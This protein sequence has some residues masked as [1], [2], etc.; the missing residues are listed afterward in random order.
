V[1]ALRKKKRQHE[2]Q[3][4]NK[5]DGFLSFNPPW[6]LMCFFVGFFWVSPCVWPNSGFRCCVCL[7]LQITLL[8]HRRSLR[9]TQTQPQPNSRRFFKN[10]VFRDCGNSAHGLAQTVARDHQI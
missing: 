9:I 2:T 6:M 4:S 8:V 7:T 1:E 10:F 3:F 5:I